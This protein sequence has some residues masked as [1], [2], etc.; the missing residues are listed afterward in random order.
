[1]GKRKKQTKPPPKKKRGRLDKIFDCPF[2]SNEKTV[3]CV[4]ER[5]SNIGRVECRVCSAK[6]RTIITRLDEEV[7]LYHKWMDAC[8]DATKDDKAAAIASVAAAS[9]ASAGRNKGP[10][11]DGDGEDDGGDGHGGNV[12]RK[13][14]VFEEEDDFLDDEEEEDD[15][16]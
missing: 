1:M 12:R 10:G 5:D 16:P 7:D 11:G 3:D 8:E 15:L 6:F 2:C 14:S 13:A 4:L 9:S